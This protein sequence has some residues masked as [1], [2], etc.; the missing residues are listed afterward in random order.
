MRALPT[1][2]PL[3]EQPSVFNQPTDDWNGI[4][5]SELA[6]IDGEQAGAEQQIGQIFPAMDP[7]SSAIDA[8]G[9]IMDQAGGALDLLTSDLNSVNFDSVILEYQGNE[10]SLYN[11]FD[12]YSIDSSAIA[13]G[14]FNDIWNVA[15]SIVNYALSQIYNVISY[16]TGLIYDLITKIDVLL[17]G[18]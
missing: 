17:Q 7:I 4:F 5:T 11:G 10:A 14:L 13:A 3:D 2:T 9:A 15:S 6:S 8:L 1:L 18:G 12:S 16:L